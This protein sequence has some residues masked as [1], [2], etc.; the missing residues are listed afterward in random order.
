MTILL[1]RLLAVLR[2]WLRAL[3]EPAPDPRGTSTPE[4]ERPHELLARVQLARAT[5][6]GAK[7]RLEGRTVDL[8]ARRWDLER[9]A[10]DALRGGRE[11]LA[12]LALQRRH[13]VGRILEDL[14]IQVRDLQHEEH[15]LTL[16]EQRLGAQIEALQARQEVSREMAELGLVLDQAEERTERLEDRARAIDRLAQAGGSTEPSLPGGGAPEHRDQAQEVEA[17]LAEL[18]RRLG[19]TDHS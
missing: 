18:K 14:E 9:Q 7:Q 4:K 6:V 2:A 15:R 8:R 1:G 17:L 16:V 11:D 12:R 13:A 10:Q 5:V 3:L 19:K